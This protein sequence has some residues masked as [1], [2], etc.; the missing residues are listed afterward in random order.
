MSKQITTDSFKRELFDLLEE[1]FE[2]VQGIYLDRGTSFFETL[3]TISA[4]EASR[5]VSAKCANIAAQVEHV[6]FYLQV[7][8]EG[9]LQKKTIGKIDW[10]ESWQLKKVTPDE[11]ELLKKE[12]REMYQTVLRA[13][14]G[15]DVWEGEDDIGASLAIL[16][17]TAYHLG[18]I[19]QALCVIK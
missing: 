13:M 7:L 12:L 9:S 8:L 14:K 16:A 10:E 6:R 2:Q 4:E 5:P 1:T 15:L 3:D 17:H 11:W 19:R 18:E